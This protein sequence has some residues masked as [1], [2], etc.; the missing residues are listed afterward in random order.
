MRT[1]KRMIM[2]LAGLLMAAGGVLTAAPPAGAALVPIRVTAIRGLGSGKCAAPVPGP[3]GVITY[4]GLPIQQF[5]CD[6]QNRTQT[7]LLYYA[8]HTTVTNLDVYHVINQATGQCLDD[9]DGRTS[10]WSPVQQWTCNDTSSTMLW[11]LGDYQNGAQQ[12]INLRAVQ[13][14][15]S[16][17][18]DVAHGSVLDGAVLQLYHCMA[19]DEAQHFYLS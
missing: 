16:T 9:R 17:C 15:G 12:L 4:N 7:W 13:N 14:G 10:D 8:G 1:P 2:T 5:T 18:L 19:G 11:A 6:N 3:D